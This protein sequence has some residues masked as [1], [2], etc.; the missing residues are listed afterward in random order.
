M[1]KFRL[2]ALA[3]LVVLPLLAA[4]CQKEVAPTPECSTTSLQVKIVEL[5][6]KPKG[7]P[8]Y[9]IWQYK[10]QGQKVYLASD[11]TCC[12]QFVTL[13]D[14][15]FN[16]LCAPSGG[17]SGKGDGRCPEFYQQATDEQLVW[18]DPR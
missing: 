5:Q 11:Q 14:G 9:T 10:W 4:R 15:C 3:A 16:V 1:R 8:A 13:Y 6:A 12:D 2:S 17:L 7:N 18:R